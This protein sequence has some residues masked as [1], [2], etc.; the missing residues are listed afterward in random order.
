VTE[1]LADCSAWGTP[2]HIVQERNSIHAI[3]GAEEAVMAQ[4]VRHNLQPDLVTEE[5]DDHVMVPV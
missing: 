1:P 4:S 2:S 3:A 5:S